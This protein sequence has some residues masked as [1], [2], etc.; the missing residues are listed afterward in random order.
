MNKYQPE[1]RGEIAAFRKEQPTNYR[2]HI[3]PSLTIRPTSWTIK[4][5]EKKQA[6][7]PKSHNILHTLF[8]SIKLK[9]RANS[10]EYI[11]ADDQQTR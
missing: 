4:F 10:R 6:R 11:C 1:T 2:S 9:I 8:H 5:H 3:I 7:T